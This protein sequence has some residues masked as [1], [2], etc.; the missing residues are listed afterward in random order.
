MPQLDSSDQRYVAGIYLDVHYTLRSHPWPF[1]GDTR[2]IKRTVEL[3]L[4]CSTTRCTCAMQC[5]AIEL[6]RADTRRKLYLHT[7]LFKRLICRVFYRC[8]VLICARSRDEAGWLFRQ[9]GLLLVIPGLNVTDTTS[10]SNS[11]N[12]SS[13]GMTGKGF[14]WNDIWCCTQCCCSCSCDV[15]VSAWRCSML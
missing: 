11:S 14:A 1:R 2:A 15:E 5:N 9:K 8:A 6:I 7:L 12:T 4:S 10:A 13:G 3:Y